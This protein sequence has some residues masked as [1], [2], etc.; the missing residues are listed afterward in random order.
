[1]FP[2]KYDKDN[3]L[4]LITRYANYKGQFQPAIWKKSEL[5]KMIKANENIW[6]SERTLRKKA[7]YHK[8][9]F[10]TQNLYSPEVVDKKEN[11]FS[12]DYYSQ[13]V[14]G[15]WS[16]RLAEYL[17]NEKIDVDLTSRGIIEFE[18]DLEKIEKAM[19]KKYSLYKISPFLYDMNQFYHYRVWPYLSEMKQ[20]IKNI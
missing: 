13:I 6:D 20:K 14:K 18:P 10:Y 5:V 7:L 17:I 9:R 8:G 3:N 15:K 2:A 16:Q 1:M 19:K 12:F 11:I 4:F